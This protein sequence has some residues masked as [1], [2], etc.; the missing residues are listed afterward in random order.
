MRPVDPRDT[1]RT[2]VRA[3]EWALYHAPELCTAAA[4]AAGG[5]LHPLLAL[6][7]VLPLGALA[8][9]E[10]RRRRDCRRIRALDL[11]AAAAQTRHRALDNALDDTQPIPRITAETTTG[12]GSGAA[13]D[14]APAGGQRG[15][16][17]R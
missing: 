11:R 2:A 10:R 7:A 14:A 4:A 6:I 12:Q 3:T 13:A 8:H 5:L 16:G 15:P 17:R 1:R 9:Q